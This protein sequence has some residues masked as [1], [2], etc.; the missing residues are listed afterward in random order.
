MNTSKYILLD[1]NILVYAAD[2]SSPYY[3]S[4]KTLR[5][6]GVKGEVFLCVC[7][8]V[9]IEFFAIVTDSKR[10]R[11]PITPIEAIKEIEKYLIAPHILKI[12]S[13]QA[14]FQN[15]VELIKKY[16]PKRQA[17]FDLQLVSTMLNSGINKIYTFN[18]IHFSKFKEIQVLTPR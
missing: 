18:K 12:Y 10:V 13:S 1:S 8:Q 7:P 15:L 14:S 3:K 11:N 9:L 2:K 4:S 5:D 17:V 16:K 6:K